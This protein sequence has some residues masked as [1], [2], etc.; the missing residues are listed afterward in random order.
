M[1]RKMIAVVLFLAALVPALQ[2]LA[3]D[4]PTFEVCA[5]TAADLETGP[6]E[7]KRLFQLK[8]SGGAAIQ[9]QYDRLLGKFRD[10]NKVA[11]KCVGITIYAA[12][13]KSY[14]SQSRY[15]SLWCDSLMARPDLIAQ[16]AEDAAVDR[17]N[18]RLEA[19]TE[20][21]AAEFRQCARM[22]SDLDS[23]KA[24][25]E[26]HLTYYEIGSMSYST[27]EQERQGL[28]RMID[29]LKSR[30]MGDWRLPAETAIGI[31]NHPAYRSTW[32]S[33]FN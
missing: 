32:C 2:V 31:C 19:E 14:C 8:A 25:Y 33:R 1:M 20:E 18:K 23:A 7:L 6:I 24:Q 3:Y 28:N 30:C 5:R 26:T 12:E 10:D 11:G 16:L 17:E 21:V 13:T 15:K 29:R 9:E 27:V 4:G 22:G